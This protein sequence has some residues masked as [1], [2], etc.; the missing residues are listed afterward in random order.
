MAN[1]KVLIASAGIGSRVE[2]YSKNFNKALI[3]VGRKPAI[4]YIIDKIPKDVEIVITVG[5][6]KDYLMQFLSLVYSDRNIKFVDVDKFS[7]EGSGLGY[8]ILKAKDEL[9]CPFMFIANDCI[10]D[11]EYTEP[12]HNFMNFWIEQDTTEYRTIR[13]QRM[14]SV[15]SELIQKGDRRSSSAAY[16]GLCGIYNYN[17]FWKFMDLGVEDGSIEQGE[18]YAISKMINSGIQFNGYPATWY[19]TGNVSKYI[20]TN[21]HFSK[22]DHINILNKEDESIWFIGDKVVKFHSDK[23]FIAQRVNRTKILGKFVPEILGFTENMYM[24]KKVDGET[25]TYNLQYDKFDKF[26]NWIGDFWVKKDL[27][28]EDK[29][30]FKNVCR[31]FY[32]DK[33]ID[34][35]ND[36]YNKYNREDC[37]EIINGKKY[38]KLSDILKRVPWDGIVNFAVPTNFHGDLHFENILVNDDSFALLDW[39]QSFGGLIE[40]GDISYDLAK[41]KH[42][43]I[44]SHEMV[45]AELYDTQI[46]GNVIN[47]YFMRKNVLSEIEK[48]FDSFIKKEGYNLIHINTLTALI[49]LNVASLHHHPYGDLLYYLGK[50]MLSDTLDELRQNS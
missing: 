32:H 29:A 43:M 24:Y 35:V 9:Q 38:E 42:G 20:E 47:F 23:T 36:Y 22:D 49:Y 31:K 16:I 34:R 45:D 10:T 40:Y 17:E 4:C 13:L 18:S 48:K 33:T 1:Y 46:N 3:T 7:G 19:D 39:R 41:L 44:I 11:E 5:Y 8:S 6:K 26:L 2:N 27:N 28:A 30:H 15:V 14:S 50:T 25:F 37:I 21:K 12:T